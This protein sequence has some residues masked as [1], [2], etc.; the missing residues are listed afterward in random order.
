[1]MN[2]QTGILLAVSSLPGNQG[3]GDFGKQAYRFL[4]ILAKQHIKIWQILPLHPLGYGNSPYQPY[5]TFAGDPIYINIDHLA[6][7]EL[8]KQSSIR[9]FNKFCDQVDY[10][11]VRAFKEPYLRKAFRV[12]KKSFQEYEA[13]YQVFCEECDWLHTFA[14][15][16]ALKKKNN[17]ASWLEW[18]KEERLWIQD[19]SQ[20]FSQLEEEIEYEKF[21][22]FM[23]YMQ[24]NDVKAYAN[25]RGISIMGDMPIYVGIDSVDVWENQSYFLLDKNGH[26]TSVAGVPPDYFSAEGQ[27]WGNPL[28]NWKR[29]KKDGYGFWIRRLRWAQQH[30][31][32]T[33]IDHF[34]GFDTY[35]K[36]PARCKTAIEGEWIEGPAY[37]LFD[38][39]Y[40]ELPDIQIVA[41]DLGD[42]RKEVGVLRDHYNLLGMRVLQFEME[43]KRLKRGLPEHVIVYTGTHDNMTLEQWYEEQGQNKKIALRRFFHN[44]GYKERNFHDLVIHFALDS[45]AEICILPMQDILGLKEEGRM[46]TPSTIGSPNWEWKLK[47]YKEVS[48]EMEKIAQWSKDSKR[49]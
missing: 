45:K 15:F 36:I 1:M 33:R 42:L 11:G 39:I 26:P 43:P 14:V 38:T 32:Y 34:R 37:D 17:N 28:Y 47:N 19:P 4:D 22:Q 27:R 21:L 44:R 9:N 16:A 7:L 24:W 31:D 29:L 8:L 13:S 41:E 5:S 23:F 30:F 48:V 20:S 2:R 10:E 12:F 25:E 35:W 49:I 6:D 40:K 46:N 18:P 3:I